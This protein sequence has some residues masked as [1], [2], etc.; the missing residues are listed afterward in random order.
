MF[1]VVEFLP[2]VVFIKVRILYAVFCLYVCAL[3]EKYIIV[4]ENI[5]RGDEI[6]LEKNKIL[7]R[8]N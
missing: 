5:T 8:R 6:K 2:S 4:I 7:K 1:V 3:K